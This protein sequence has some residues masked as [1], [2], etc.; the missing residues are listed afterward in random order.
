MLLK[1]GV[2]GFIVL[3]LRVGMFPLY[4]QSFIGILLGGQ[5]SL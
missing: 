3:W 4:G 2:W 5:Q 1:F